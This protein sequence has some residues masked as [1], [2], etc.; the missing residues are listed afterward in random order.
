MIL[1]HLMITYTS[2]DKHGPIRA[3]VRDYKRFSAIYLQFFAPE[4]A[5]VLISD[6]EKWKFSPN[7]QINSTRD[8]Q[9]DEILLSSSP[10]A[11][12]SIIDFLNRRL[13]SIV[14]GPK[15]YPKWK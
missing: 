7:S 6:V 14:F 12:C 11:I 9:F 4:I 13:H 8:N 1:S 15:Y 2:Q 5:R 3:Q 10:A